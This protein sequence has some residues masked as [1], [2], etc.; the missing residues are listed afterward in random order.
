[1]ISEPVFDLSPLLLTF[2]PSPQL[3]IDN[4]LHAFNSRFP[5]YV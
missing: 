2:S 5:H 1:M 4:Y 3:A